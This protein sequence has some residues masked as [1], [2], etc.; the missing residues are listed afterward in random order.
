MHLVL[1][2][3]RKPHDLG[4]KHK[5][6][7][8]PLKSKCGIIW[9]SMSRFVSR[10]RSGHSGNCETICWGSSIS[11]FL[12][13]VSKHY[14]LLLREC[15]KLLSGIILGKAGA[16]LHL[17]PAGKE[18]CSTANLLLPCLSLQTSPSTNQGGIS[19]RFTEADYDKRILSCKTK[20]MSELP[21][22]W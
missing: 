12:K 14:C 4:S 17:R 10:S 16:S 20:Y 5:R 2:H 13:P 7:C 3:L 8:T 6:V 15:E 18:S 21:N 9:W 22:I 11:P 19:F 1:D